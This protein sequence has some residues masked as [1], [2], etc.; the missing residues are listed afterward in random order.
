MRYGKIV[1]SLQPIS[2]LYLLYFLLQHVT[3]GDEYLL[4]GDCRCWFCWRSSQ[5]MEDIPT[6]LKVTLGVLNFNQDVSFLE[7]TPGSSLPSPA[8]KGE[9]SVL[10]LAPV[11]EHIH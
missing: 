4:Q 2:L 3:N 10:V 7:L 5:E 6:T 8:E 11:L 9:S 1:F